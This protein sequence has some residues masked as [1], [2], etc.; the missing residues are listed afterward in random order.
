MKTEWASC[1]YQWESVLSGLTFERIFGLSPGTKRTVRNNGMSVLIKG[2]S[3]K[4][5]STVVTKHYPILLDEAAG[6]KFKL[7]LTLQRK[8]LVASDCATAIC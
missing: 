7:A 2:V 1:P 5:G 3:V 8:S 6:F 4:R